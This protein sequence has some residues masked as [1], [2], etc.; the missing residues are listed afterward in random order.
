MHFWLIWELL[1]NY[2]SDLCSKTN[3]VLFTKFLHIRPN[4][5]QFAR[6]SSY[7]IKSDRFIARHIKIP[8]FIPFFSERT[9][10]YISL[11]RFFCVLRLKLLILISSIRYVVLYAPQ[12]NILRR[13]VN[14]TDSLLFNFYYFRNA[15]KNKWDFSK[16]LSSPD[17]IWYQNRI[18][19]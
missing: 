1:L 4:T 9:Q 18:Q 6:I 13:K 11:F 12:P 3:P 8:L 16:S 14:R 5:R 15:N 17:N 10:W 7:L 2:V 19:Q